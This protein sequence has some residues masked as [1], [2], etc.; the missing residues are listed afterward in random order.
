MSATLAQAMVDAVHRTPIAARET[1][2][3]AILQ[4]LEPYSPPLDPYATDLAQF[5]ADF[6]DNILPIHRFT[7]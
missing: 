7:A 1:D 3:D 6:V 2:L 4:L 5:G